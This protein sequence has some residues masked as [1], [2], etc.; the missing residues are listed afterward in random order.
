MDGASAMS[1]QNLIRPDAPTVVL[2]SASVTRRRLLEEAGIEVHVEPARVDE[3]SIKDS[4]KAESASPAQAAE[5]L[6][7]LKTRKISDR[8]PQALV[9]GADQLMDCEGCW[10]DKPRSLTEAAEHL[11]TLSGRTHRLTSAAVTMRG[12]NR[13]WHAVAEARLTMRVLEADFIDRYLAAIGDA[14]L[15]SVGG[16]QLEGL[17]AQLFARIEGDYF[18]VLGLPLLPLLGALRDQGVLRR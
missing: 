18:T 7:E 17:G 16:Y 2:A 15:T 8:H 3:D 12:S 11:R 4:L 6:A 1:E 10:F 13:T 5:T 14:A 9:I